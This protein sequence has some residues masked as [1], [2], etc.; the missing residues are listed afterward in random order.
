MFSS[1]YEC[2][3]AL[4]ARPLGAMCWSLVMEFPNRIHLF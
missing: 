1:S 2:L 4:V 3:C